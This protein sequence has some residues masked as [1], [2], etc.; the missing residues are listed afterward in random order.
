MGAKVR[1]E[2]GHTLSFAGAGTVGD[3]ANI[4]GAT[5]FGAGPGQPSGVASLGGLGTGMPPS[6]I[7]QPLAGQ[8]VGAPGG[9]TL[10]FG[11]V[12]IVG[13][14]ANIARA[15]VLKVEAAKI[16]TLPPPIICS[17]KSCKEKFES[18]YTNAGSV[19]SASSRRSQHEGGCKGGQHGD[20]LRHIAHV[21]EEKWEFT[22]GPVFSFDVTLRMIPSQNSTS[23]KA[24]SLLSSWKSGNGNAMHR[25][26]FDE[27]MDSITTSASEFRDALVTYFGMRLSNRLKETKWN[28]HRYITVSAGKVDDAERQTVDITLQVATFK[29]DVADAMRGALSGSFQ[30]TPSAAVCEAL[31]L[32][33]TCT[34]MK[35][36]EMSPVI[37][38]GQGKQICFHGGGQNACF[39]AYEECMAESH[40]ARA[41]EALQISIIRK[42]Q[43]EAAAKRAQKVQR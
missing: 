23:F 3:T 26:F 4:A 31:K 19:S 1:G 41:V 21:G 24:L 18:N 2:R 28:P 43:E 38:V 25:L 14:T 42:K 9:T 16:K 11:G 27:L 33:G 35:V 10:S 29:K 17:H 20:V 30:F 8:Y 40:Q 37:T 39:K 15:T 32:G 7:V 36:G 13:D 22:D 12:G 5:A 34:V 6:S